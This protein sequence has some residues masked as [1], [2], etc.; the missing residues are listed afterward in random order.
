MKKL[1]YSLF[2]L[3]MTA[4]TFTACEDVPAPYD[5]PTENK[6]GEPGE[7]VE[8]TGTGTEADPFNIAAINSY[9][10]NLA[11]GEKSTENLYFKGK[12][13]S[14]KENFGYVNDKGQ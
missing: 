2:A 8:P 10:K 12:V 13:V 9:T 6:G 14:I 7:S 5:L 1:F 3:A 4:M 11:S